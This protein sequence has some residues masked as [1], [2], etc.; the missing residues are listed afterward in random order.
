M[1][2]THSL[3]QTH[4]GRTHM[5]ASTKD[6]TKVSSILL[7][8]ILT[9]L[10]AGLWNIWIQ[11]RQMKVMNRLLGRKK[12]SFGW[13]LFLTIITFGLYHIYHEY[14]MSEDIAMVMGMQDKLLPIVSLILSIFAASI[15]CDAVQ[16]SYIN[17]YYGSDE[18]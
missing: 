5:V 6:E 14:R 17:R 18:V 11:Y 15:V 8:I 3:K 9:I 1:D 12:Y 2:A 7:D 4:T 13:W 16:Q 10:T